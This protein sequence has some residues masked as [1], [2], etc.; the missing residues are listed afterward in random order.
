MKSQRAHQSTQTRPEVTRPRLHLVSAPAQPEIAVEPLH[1]ISR[2]L[3]P[4]F[5]RFHQEQGKDGVELDPDWDALL[6]M[7]VQ[8]GLRIVT[9]RQDGVLVGFILNTVGA[10]L[11]Y[12]GTL[13]ASTIAYW[14]DPAL[15][16]GWFPIKLMR[17]NVELL[18]E[19][20]VKRA[21]IAVDVRF[22]DGR[23]GKVFE[24]LG[25]HIHETHYA[26]VF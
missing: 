10:P 21:F 5:V 2:E 19:W 15:R 18:R 1:A 11:F 14:L 13:H 24:R 7:T 12:R 20:G 23:M 9:V 8:G 17:R 25:Y 26:Q 6:R 3:T 4:L 16:S 22:K